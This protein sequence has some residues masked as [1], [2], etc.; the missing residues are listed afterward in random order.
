MYAVEHYCS[1]DDSSTYEIFETLNE[2]Q[3]FSE[4]DIWNIDNYPLYIFKAKFNCE[5]I[6]LENS[7][8]NYDDCIDTIIEYLDYYKEL[9]YE[10]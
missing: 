7:E 8:W 3:F 6:Y 2:A 1:V 4:K 9:K 10:F 5:R